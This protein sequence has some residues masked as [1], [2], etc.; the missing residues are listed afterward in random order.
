M[1]RP[2]LTERERMYVALFVG[3]IAFLHLCGICIAVGTFLAVLS[4]MRK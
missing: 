3:T 2:P 4:A 1:S